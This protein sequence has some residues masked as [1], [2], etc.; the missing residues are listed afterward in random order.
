MARPEGIRDSAKAAARRRIGITEDEDLPHLTAGS[1]SLTIKDEG[2][3][4]QTLTTTIDFI[5]AAVVAASTGPQSASITV[6]A[7]GGGTLQ[8]QEFTS[9]GTWTWPTGVTAAW[10]TMVGGGNGGNGSFVA[11]TGAGGGSSGE[12]AVAFPVAKQAATATVTIGAG[13]AGG[14][15][16]TPGTAGGDTSFDTITVLGGRATGSINS[17]GIGGGPKGGASSVAGTIETII[18]FGGSGGGIGGTGGGNGGSAPGTGGFL[19]GAAGGTLVGGQAG[20]GGGASSIWGKGGVGGNGG[21]AGT[22]ASA[23]A[24]GSGGGGAGGFAGGKTGGN[25]C[26]GYCL[27]IWVG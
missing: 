8:S 1:G 27:V 25:A 16:N 13:G 18:H 21:V 3:V 19:L 15:V 20:G 23:T 4:V 9:N 11:L 12:F 26:A 24:Y 7:S 22:A 2:V 10:I 6:T 17:G 14:A 5:G